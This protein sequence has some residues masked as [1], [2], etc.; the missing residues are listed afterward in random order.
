MNVKPAIG[1]LTKDGQ[2]PF[3]DKVTAILQ[4]MANNPAYPT[5]LP[6]LAL[7]Q[8]AFDAYKVA[9]ADA[10]QGGVQNTAI[11]D[12]R[13]AELV[14]LLRQLA[15][16]VSATANGD[17]EKLLS[18]GFPVQKPG[19]SPIGPLPA[20][21]AP[22]VAQGPVSGA[23]KATAAPVRGAY[24]YN[25]SVALESAPDK[26]VQSAQ[27]TG[28]RASFSGLTPGQVYVVSLNA[29]GAAGVSDWSDY[30]SLMVI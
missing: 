12:A 2:A 30:G 6:T 22:A 24:A 28:A 25:W 29:V 8:T 20:P 23:L 9:A 18:S 26:D 14:S 4:W 27:T 17:L 13:R 21:D 5:P 11:R 19:R 1:F 7:V 10:V 15:A 16:Y 3:T